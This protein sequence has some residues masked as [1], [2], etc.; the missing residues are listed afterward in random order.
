ME[1][2]EKVYTICDN[3]CL[4]ESLTK[5]QIEEVVE[6]EVDTK[7]RGYGVPVGSIMNYDGTTP[8]AGFEETTNVSG[9]LNDLNTN[10]KTNL[11]NAINEV[12]LDVNNLE[13]VQLYSYTGTTR[14]TSI[15]LSDNYSNYT[16]IEIYGKRNSMYGFIKMHTDSNI[17]DFNVVGKNDQYMEISNTHMSFNN[18]KIT[19]TGNVIVFDTTSG[20]VAG[21]DNNQ[22]N[23]IT[24]IYGYK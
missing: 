1:G 9:N 3:M 13:P 2:H 23:V 8:P 20:A 16:F 12:N 14:Q 5:V 17:T 6:T 18:K 11:V 24:K 7:V 10:D 15:T 4:E 19:L 21:Y 22:Q